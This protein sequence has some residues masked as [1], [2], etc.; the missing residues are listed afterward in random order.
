MTNLDSIFNSREWGTR[1]HL[2]QIHVDLWQNQYHIV[3]FKNKIKFKK[4]VSLK[5][6]I[7]KTETSVASGPVT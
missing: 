7:Q 1:V 2:W 5:L 4:K 3:K 6:N